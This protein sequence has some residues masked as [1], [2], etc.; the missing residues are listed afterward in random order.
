M[1]GSKAQKSIEPERLWLNLS[2]ACELA[3][4]TADPFKKLMKS[5]GFDVEV[6]GGHQGV[7]YRICGQGLADYLSREKEKERAA[8]EQR[9]AQILQLFPDD[10][11]R[12]EI[13]TNGG[14]ST[15]REVNEILEA[16]R[17]LDLLQAGRGNLV[18]AAELTIALEQ[19]FGA[20][21]KELQEKMVDMIS[22]ELGFDKPTRAKLEQH[23]ADGLKRVIQKLQ[24]PETYETS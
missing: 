21:R 17:R 15:T 8:E 6:E 11:F 3:G 10:V 4:L 19:A 20:L 14:P 7:P 13:P 22:R 12:S 16:Q 9:Q 1:A 18:D 23:V 24:D 5:P 2:E